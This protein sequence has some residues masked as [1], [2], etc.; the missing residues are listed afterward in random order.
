[1]TLADVSASLTLWRDALVLDLQAPRRVLSSA[2][3]GGGLTESRYLVNRTVPHDFCP[4]DVQ[5]AARA[6]LRALGL[7]EG[8]VTCA[9]T[10][11]DVWNYASG[12]AEERGVRATAFVTAGLGNLSAP[13][14]T[15]LADRAPGTIN[16][17]V[18]IEADLPDAALVEAVQMITEVKARTLA[19]RVTEG[20]H[21]ATGTSTDTVTLALL[22][23]ARHDFS[24]PLTPPGRA[25]ARAFQDALEGALA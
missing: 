18:L 2:P 9:L 19:G 22:P 23:G 15:P 24:G 21:P 25:V 5:N 17:F 10:S 11:V 6:E 14:L 7:P 13:G 16:A 8:G 4:P 12:S 1:V 3:L 20:G